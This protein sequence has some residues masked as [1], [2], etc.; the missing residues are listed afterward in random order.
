MI[1][2]MLAL[3]VAP[4][5]DSTSLS[6]PI[7]TGTSKKTT[8]LPNMS[9]KSRTNFCAVLFFMR[10][11]CCLPGFSHFRYLETI[12]LEA[13]QT[14]ATPQTRTTPP[15]HKHKPQRMTLTRSIHE[16]T[17]LS[18][19]FELVGSGR[20]RVMPVLTTVPGLIA[21]CIWLPMIL[22]TKWSRQGTS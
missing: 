1:D 5:P 11:S 8:A 15:S 6:P 22:Q 16:P 2:C 13:V 9:Q 3:F 14:H 20:G 18:A 4:F 7:T 12:Q 21:W 19:G 17:P 10:C